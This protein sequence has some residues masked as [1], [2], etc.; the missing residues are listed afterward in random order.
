M[1]SSRW[2]LPAHAA[3]GAVYV[4]ATALFGL[5]NASGHL[6]RC[7]RS[8][9]RWAPTTS[10]S[11]PSPSSTQATVTEVPLAMTWFRRHVWCWAAP[12]WASGTVLMMAL[13]PR[14]EPWLRET[15]AGRYVYAVGNNPEATRLVG[16]PTERVLLGGT[17]LAGST[18]RRAA[19]GGPYR[20]AIPNAGQTEN[21]GRHHGRRLAAPRRSYGACS[22]CPSAGRRHRGG[23]A[24]C[25]TAP[26]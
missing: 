18:A 2:T 12:T 8:S 22:R 16:I 13:Y 10:L 20:R 21:L 19:V 4:G 17:V 5:A 6:D 14:V 11:L 9:S 23:R 24:R 1:T 26:R 3:G 25:A 15:A 7:R